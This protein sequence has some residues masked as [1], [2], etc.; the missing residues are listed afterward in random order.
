MTGSGRKGLSVGERSRK[1]NGLPI[2]KIDR[3]SRG[4]TNSQVL[5][6]GNYAELVNEELRL[7]KFFYFF[8]KGLNRLTA[9]FGLA[10][11]P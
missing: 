5:W 6:G 11:I 1:E 2:G 8:S 4:G 10:K 7:K 3:P 9:G